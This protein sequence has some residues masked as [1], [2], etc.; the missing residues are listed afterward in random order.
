MSC[1][2]FELN[3]QSVSFILKA[4]LGKECRRLLGVAQIGEPP[5]GHE[6]DAVEEVEDDGVGLVDGAEDRLAGGREA[7]EHHDHVLRHVRV[8]ARSG[9]V[10]EEQGR[11][12]EDL[13][14]EGQQFGLSARDALDPPGYSDQRVRASR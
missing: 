9:L 1:L 5:L 6:E 2:S 8:E 3:C 12:G 13:A 4:S 11:V 10:A 14:R 7:L